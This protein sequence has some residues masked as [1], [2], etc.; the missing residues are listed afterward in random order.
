MPTKYLVATTKTQ[1]Q[2]DD[3][4]CYADPGE[5]V[6]YAT[7]C[8]NK[9]CGCTWSMSGITTGKGTTT[10]EVCE[11]TDSRFYEKLHSEISCGLRENWRLSSA[12]A[13]RG[14]TEYIDDLIKVAETFEAGDIIEK[15]GERWR[16]RVALGA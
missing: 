14:A 11:T 1:G 16:K 3:D 10:I 9:H 6:Q 8:A 2:R 5:S 7:E 12:Q 4:F 13:K 15:R